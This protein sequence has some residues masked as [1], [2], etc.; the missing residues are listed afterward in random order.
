MEHF[1]VLISWLRF[2]HKGEQEGYDQYDN[3]GEEIGFTGRH[4]FKE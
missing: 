3:L 2:A 1:F 4:E